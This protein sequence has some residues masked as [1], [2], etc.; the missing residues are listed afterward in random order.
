MLHFQH[1]TKCDVKHHKLWR[2]IACVPGNVP[3]VSSEYTRDC[4]SHIY[5]RSDRTKDTSGSVA[6]IH[7]FFS[8]WYLEF[9]QRHFYC[10]K[11]W[12]VPVLNPALPE[13]RYNRK[14][15]FLSF[16]YVSLSVTCLDIVFW[17]VQGHG[18][19]I[20]ILF[21]NPIMTSWHA[22]DI[23]QYWLFVRGINRP[24]VDFPYKGRVMQTFDD[25][26]AV[27]INNLLNKQSEKLPII[28]DALVS[29]PSNP[30]PY[31]YHTFK[32]TVLPVF[33]TFP[34]EQPQ[35]NYIIEFIVLFCSWE[36]GTV[37]IECV[38]HCN[39]KK[40]NA[41]PDIFLCIWWYYCHWMGCVRCRTSWTLPDRTQVR[42]T[43]RSI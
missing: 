13:H 15:F 29:L 18:N 19:S 1:H 2:V 17:P 34:L 16:C 5:N 42:G 23:P 26:F 12:M 21:V 22:Q 25:V 4:V 7:L 8:I 41:K 32:R 6:N 30:L 9:K 24:L 10:R 39:V 3:D 40:L 28:W 43:T 33:L 38:L 37:W 36:H 35:N 14:Y 31:P 27:N 20:V 11:M